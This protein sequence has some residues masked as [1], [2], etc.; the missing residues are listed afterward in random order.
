MSIITNF[1]IERA[2]RRLPFIHVSLLAAVAAVAAAVACKK[3]ATFPEPAVPK[4]AITWVNAVSDTGQ[5]DFRIVDI[6][7]NAGFPDA[8]FRSALVYPQGI[9]SGTRHIKVFQSD[10]LPQNSKVVILDTTFTFQANQPYSFTL[11]GFARTG[12]TPA[13]SG[14]IESPTVPTPSST[15]FAIRVLNLAP[16]LAGATPA[17]TDTTVPADAYVRPLSTLPSGTPE[18][19]N[20]AFGQPTAYVSLDTATF[21]TISLTP[22]GA[23]APVFVQAALPHGQA[24][25]AVSN[26]LGGSAIAGTVMTAVI[27]PR[28]VLS[29]RAPQTRPRSQITD[30]STAEASRRITRSNDTVTVQVGSIS[31]LVNRGT[32]KADST[33]G[34][35]GTGAT[36]GVSVGDVVLVAGATQPEYNSWHVLIAGSGSLGGAVVADSLS[37]NPVNANDTRA[38]CAGSNAVATTRFRFRYRISGTPV[39]PG[40]GAVTYRLYTPLSAADF[41]IPFVTFVIDKRPPNTA[42]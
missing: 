30:T 15:Q 16:S 6:P 40:G 2:M 3:D 27:L 31:V 29:S 33:V 7:T 35:S 37:C 34:I 19:T 25:N 20:A 1:S 4:A 21:Y 26:P 41:A 22:T 23:G 28:S 36:P 9:E 18:V 14:R 12:Q 42:K 39:S 5:L 11:S 13:L 10:S 8:N 32:G 38:K 24:G 17:L